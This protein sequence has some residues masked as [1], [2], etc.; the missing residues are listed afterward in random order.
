MQ[1]MNKPQLPKLPP[2]PPSS[3]VETAAKPAQGVAVAGNLVACV[4]VGM[5]LGWGVDWLLGSQPWGLI[6]G[7]VLGFAAWLR[8]LWGLIS[9][10]D[11]T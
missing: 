11:K 10:E 3:G 5:L 2:N 4:L 7:L 1:P 8:E 9:N 6:L